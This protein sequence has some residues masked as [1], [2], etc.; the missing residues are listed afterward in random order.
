MLRKMERWSKL[1]SG[2]STGELT[3]A[4]FAVAAAR[5]AVT[6][7]SQSACHPNTVQEFR[8]GKVRSQGWMLL[9]NWMNVSQ[10][11]LHGIISSHIEGVGLAA[12]LWESN[13][14]GSPL[15]RQILEP[16]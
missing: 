11:K 1:K 16:A 8:N 3:F 7:G 10:P 5:P 14:K 12:Y 13:T 9:E 2:R 6:F 4:R 15:S